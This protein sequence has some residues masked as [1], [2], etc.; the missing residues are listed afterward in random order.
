MSWILGVY[1]PAVDQSDETRIAAIVPPALHSIVVGGLCVHAGG[2]PETC[3]SGV[4]T[5][6][7]ATQGWVVVG[8]GLVSE[9]G[10]A[11]IIRP[12]EWR[13]VLF[14]ETTL[15]RALDGHYAGIRWTPGMFR[16][17]CDPL[18]LR[19]MYYTPVGEGLAFSTRID[20]LAHFSEKR[21]LDYRA[22]GS[23][24]TCFHQIGYDSGIQGI[25]RLPPG[26]TLTFT[27][28]Q[29][30]VESCP[31]QPSFTP[32]APSDVSAHLS[33]LSDPSPPDG[34]SLSLGLSGGIDSRLLLAVRY[35]RH[36]RRV[37]VHTFGDPSD[38]D[39]RIPT[40]I[41]KELGLDA[42]LLHEPLQ[43]PATLIPLVQ[44]YCA[45]TMLIE[46]ASSS[47]KL[48]YYPRIRAEKRFLIDGGFGE[49]GRRQYFN[50]LRSFGLAA[51][52]R[53]DPNLMRKWISVHRP[54]VF[55]REVVEMMAEGAVDDMA[56]QLQL[57]PAPGE[58]GI[59][60]FLDLLAV[61]TR[62]PN[63]GGPEQGRLDAAV[64]NLMPLVQPS[65]LR[66]VFG[67]PVGLRRKASLIRKLIARSVP[68]LARHRLAKS[69][70]EYPFWMAGTTAV[71]YTK[72]LRMAGRSFHDQSR[73]TTLLALREFIQDL[74]H[75]SD[76]KAFDA[77]EPG[78]VQRLVDA[79]YGGHTEAEADVDWWLA[80]ELWRR[81]LGGPNS[82]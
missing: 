26:G 9:R 8:A 33:V 68:T 45:E 70:S 80:F 78:T 42:M 7:D 37:L 17:F 27:S 54:A 25:G 62:V 47:L 5:G 63:Y 65:Y 29:L 79:Y 74:A 53:G 61:R 82:G 1:R 40:E 59:E 56:L 21:T 73:K 48:R 11:R 43:K 55:V 18:G 81:A 14:S 3:A 20:W 64:P 52:N 23:R 69:G 10:R 13:T 30:K 51:M 15:P 49:L 34:N 36:G 28:R 2:L 66:L 31:W 4:D 22:M 38:P 16:L 35:A 77:Y 12:S 19:F 76:T 39:V 41:A 46:P 32:V 44:A 6:S 58:I 72:M 71:L 50:R 67:L 57:L 24:W 75:S 60:N